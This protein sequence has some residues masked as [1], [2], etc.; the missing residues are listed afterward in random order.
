MHSVQAD[1][2]LKGKLLQYFTLLAAINLYLFPLVVLL[3]Q[4]LFPIPMVGRMLALPV[5]SAEVDWSVAAGG[6]VLG[7]VFLFLHR[8]FLQKNV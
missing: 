1:L 5:T 7:S 6:V 3:Y 8:C 4:V 2:H